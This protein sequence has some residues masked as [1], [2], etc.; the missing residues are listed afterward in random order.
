MNAVPKNSHLVR[1]LSIDPG[2]TN[3]G[4]AISDFNLDT[5]IFGVV[6][7]GVITA[8]KTAKKRKDAVLEFGPRFIALTVVQEEITKLLLQY[9]PHFVGAEDTFFNPRTPQAHI[10]LLL[11][12]SSI[13][14]VLYQL[15]MKNELT[16]S[17]AKKL[18]KMSPMTVKMVVSEHGHSGKQQVLDSIKKNTNIQFNQAAN[19]ESF[20]ETLVLADHESDAIAVGYTLAKNTVI[21]RYL[22]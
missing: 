11:C 17:T 2:T 14:T 4:W 18:Y 21:D 12:L 16:H 13:D 8:I 19:D 9:Q 10:S 7:Y 5:G 22:T 6:N 3:M 20:K 15:Y 1:I